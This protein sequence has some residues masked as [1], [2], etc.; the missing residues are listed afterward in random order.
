M[1]WLLIPSPRYLEH[2]SEAVLPTPFAKLRDLTIGKHPV[3][4]HGLMSDEVVAVAN[5]ISEP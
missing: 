3:N 5:E 1:Y 4:P 2:G